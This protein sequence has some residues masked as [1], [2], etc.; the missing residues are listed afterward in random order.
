MV[1]SEVDECRSVIWGAVG[2]DAKLLARG[3]DVSKINVERETVVV[4]EIQ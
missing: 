1:E 3:C 4:D 2:R